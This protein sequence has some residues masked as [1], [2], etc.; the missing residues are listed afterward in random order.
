MEDTYESMKIK[1]DISYNLSTFK[2]TF[3]ISTL[4]MA[5]WSQ[6]LCIIC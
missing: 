1:T 3:W 5:F 2:N 6:D 4:D